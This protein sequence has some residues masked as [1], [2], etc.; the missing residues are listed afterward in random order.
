MNVRRRTLIGAGLVSLGA[1]VPAP[2]G[3]AAAGTEP[4]PPSFPLRPSPDGRYLVDQTGRAFFIQGDSPQ[5]IFQRLTLQE[6]DDYLSHRRAQGFTT[7]LTD[8]TFSNNNDG[9]VRPTRDGQFPCLV[10]CD[11][12]AYRGAAGTADFSS[13]NPGYWDHVD[14]VLARAEAHGFLVLHYVLAWGFKGRTMWRDLINRCNT[15]EI[16]RRFGEF[17]GARFRHR[18]NLIWID[19][20]DFDGS[21]MLRG[22]DGTSGIARALSITQGMRA[23]GATQLRTGDW[24]ADSISTDQTLFAPFMS[25]N[26]IYTY[27]VEADYG[28]SYY[29]ARRAYRR[30]PRM[31][32]FLKETWYEAENAVRGLPAYVRKHEWWN[33]LSGA[34]A[35][36]VYGHGDVWPFVQGR[37]RAALDAPG[38]GDMQRMGAFM[39][40]L[41]WHK[42]IPSELAGTRRLV[43]SDNGRADPPRPTYVAA[44]QDPDGTLL[45]AY[46]PPSG[47]G[48]QS[49]TLDLRGMRGPTAASWWDP[50]S[51]RS[52]F[53]GRYPTGAAADLATPGDNDGGANDWVLLVRSVS[54]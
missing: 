49:A 45:L 54:A 37:W 13:P 10:N 40:G 29:V 18:I 4:R 32:A 53:A 50:T 2:R 36:V 41:A 20:S 26:G 17:L 43:I 8:P 12:T 6:V 47:R 38:A 28:S 31:P 24:S 34:T 30:T 19:G 7:L 51:A 46:V 39:R 25:V 33:L 22:P 15:A 21:D 11:G 3:T 5:A 48:R 9:F 1:T 23:A 16:C 35:G 52:Q 44:A 42:L 14:M 27:G